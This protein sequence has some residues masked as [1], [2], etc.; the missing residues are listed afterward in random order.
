[1]DL[2]QQRTSEENTIAEKIRETVKRIQGQIASWEL[3]YVLKTPVAGKV[4][5][6]KFWK[7]N[8]YVDNG[9]S[10][11]MI[12]PP[13]QNYLARA[14]LPVAGAGK[15]KAGQKVLIKL[16]SYPFEEY[17]MINGKVQTVS[18]VSLDTSYAMEIQLTSALT[19][20]SGKSIPPQPQLSGTAEVLTNDKNIFE[21]LFSILWRD[22]YN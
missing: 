1:M 8:Q 4:V 17:G 20:S 6:F 21:R 7:E 19:T 16:S 22:R 10:V 13:V 5:F 12:V 2:Q 18:A 3:K 11:L 14:F 9:E 15:V